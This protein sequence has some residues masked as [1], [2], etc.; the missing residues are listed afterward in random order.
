MFLKVFREGKGLERVEFNGFFQIDQGKTSSA[1]RNW[2]NFATQA[3][4]FAIVFA[5]LSIILLWGKGVAIY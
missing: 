1:A 5:S 2:T 4:A 3:D